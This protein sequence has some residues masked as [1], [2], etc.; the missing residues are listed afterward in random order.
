M[1]KFI[2]PKPLETAVLFLVF[3][4]LDTTMQ[5]FAEI[6][7]AKPP[8]LYIASDGARVDKSGED[9]IVDAVRK[10]ILDNIDWDCEVKTL[11]REKNLGCKYAVS[12]AI[13]WFFEHEEQGI[14][15]E[16]DC[17]PSQSFFWYCEELLNKYK[18]NDTIAMISGDNLQ[19][20][21]QRGDASYYFSIF[22]HIWGWASWQR[23]WQLYD[24]EFFS[25]N[26][27]SD[28]LYP[29]LINYNPSYKLFWNNLYRAIKKLDA[30]DYQFT[31]TCFKYKM[32]CINPNVNLI[33]NIGFGKNATHT[34]DENSLYANLPRYD[35]PALLVHPDVIQADSDAD[36]L[37]SNKFFRYSRPRLI[38]RIKN[39]IKRYL[40]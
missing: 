21:Q 24:V 2:P 5:V 39:M 9:E 6:K 14:I 8:R 33:S 37:V 20:G 22:P 17:L 28:L 36:L 3:N 32:L 38:I 13:S 16:D 40:N 26:K 34:L 35:L 27:K 12:G 30:W 29:E 25:N 23:S 31:F 4:R 7:K 18:D 1:T 15:L 10:Y 11:F 19:D